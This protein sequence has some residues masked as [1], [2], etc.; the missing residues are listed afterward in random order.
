L[1]LHNTQDAKSDYR[2][3]GNKFDSHKKH[4]ARLTPDSRNENLD[5]FPMIFQKISPI[6]QANSLRANHRF[7]FNKSSQ[8]FIRSHNATLS[9]VAVCISYPD[10]SPVAIHG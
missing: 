3:E 10:R 2:Y 7:Q 6:R 4:F 8:L 5:P 1:S 9:V